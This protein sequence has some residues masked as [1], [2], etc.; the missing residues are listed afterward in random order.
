MRSAYPLEKGRRAWEHDGAACNHHALETADDSLPSSIITALGG[1]H[2]AAESAHLQLC[3][4]RRA[5]EILQSI[6]QPTPVRLQR[7]L[8]AIEAVLIRKGLPRV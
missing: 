3:L 5:A 4:A 7:C 1:K 2:V 6:V 8:S